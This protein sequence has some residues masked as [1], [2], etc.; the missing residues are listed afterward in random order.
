LAIAA[1]AGLALK[2]LQKF[3]RSVPHVVFDPDLDGAH[4]PAWRIAQHNPGRNWHAL[5]GVERRPVRNAVAVAILIQSQSKS[6]VLQG[7]RYD[8][9][10]F[11]RT[12]FV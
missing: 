3:G 1:R 10:D 11:L 9:P 4:R 6:E 8:Y 5:D 7:R 2:A 12:Q